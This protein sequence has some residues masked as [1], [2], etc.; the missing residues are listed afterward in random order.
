VKTLAG[1]VVVIAA[2]A[3]GSVPVGP[4]FAQGARPE[5]R[6]SYLFV[7]DGRN[8]DL[9]RVVGMPNS[10]QL[11]VPL[12]GQNQRVTWFTD[13]P[14]RN[15]GQVMM[16]DFVGLW[17]GSGRDS[18]TQD[19]PNVAVAFDGATVIA[20]MK[21]PRI[22][23]TQDGGHALV[24]RLTLVKGQALV[25]VAKSTSGIAGHAKRAGDNQLPPGGRLRNVSVFVD[26]SPSYFNCPDI[27]C[28]VSE[29]TE[30]A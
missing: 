1:S 11:T 24:T 28:S 15:A 4:V 29:G 2:L 23:D 25:G 21:N 7:F 30:I 9:K 5:T 3:I 20:T 16:K 10:L 17:Q 14:V 6:A 13:R 26:I 19:P 22:V 18:F 27:G 12:R 8:A